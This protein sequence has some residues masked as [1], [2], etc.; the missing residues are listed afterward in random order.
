MLI[1]CF[2]WLERNNSK[3]HGYNFNSDRIILKVHQFINTISRTKLASSGNWKGDSHIVATMGF[4]TCVK[5]RATLMI[6]K[7]QQM[8]CCS[9]QPQQGYNMKD[10]AT[11]GAFCS[12]RDQTCAPNNRASSVQMKSKKDLGNKKEEG[13][14]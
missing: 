1:L 8:K 7:V 13:T 9:S 5:R 10:A 4:P 12:M 2:C 3:H 14:P 6:F 11:Q